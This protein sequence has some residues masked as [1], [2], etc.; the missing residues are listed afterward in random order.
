MLSKYIKYKKKGKVCQTMLPK[1]SCCPAVIVITKANKICYC[2]A[3][4]M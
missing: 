3:V 2:T 4:I 1:T